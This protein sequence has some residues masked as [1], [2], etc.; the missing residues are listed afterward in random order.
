MP[1][2]KPLAALVALGIIVGAG[3]TDPAAPNSDGNVPDASF[4]PQKISSAHV[5]LN[6]R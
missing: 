1:L 2:K 5:S 4:T 3:C 6:G